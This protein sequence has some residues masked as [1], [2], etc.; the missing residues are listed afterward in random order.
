MATKVPANPDVGVSESICGRTVKLTLLLKALPS[1]TTTG[2]VDAPRGTG[3]VIDV[4]LQLVGT[5]IVPLKVTELVPCDDPKLEP[6]M[7]T[8]VPTIPEVG[9]IEL[10]AAGIVK[11]IPLLVPVKYTEMVTGPLVAPDGTG[12]VIEVLLQ[13]VVLH[14]FP[15]GGASNPLNLTELNPL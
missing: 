4:L 13:L 5:A 7:V 1:A 14:K 8:E 10:M 12:T 6:E 15:A 11:F 9:D 2:P 3:T